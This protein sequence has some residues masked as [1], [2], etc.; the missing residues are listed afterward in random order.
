MYSAVAQAHSELWRHVGTCLLVFL[1]TAATSRVV[2]VKAQHLSTSLKQPSALHKAIKHLHVNLTG[3][4][5]FKCSLEMVQ[6]NQ[7]A[8]ITVRCV[9]QTEIYI[10]TWA[11]HGS[12]ETSYNELCKYQLW[13]DGSITVII[14]TRNYQFKTQAVSGDTDTLHY[15]IKIFRSEVIAK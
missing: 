9:H 7:T 14:N 1:D 11:V 8:D 6:R 12:L 3:F 2:Y 5:R 10:S 13:V 15:N 4:G